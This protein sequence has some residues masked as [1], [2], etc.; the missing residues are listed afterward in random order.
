MATV[1]ERLA[2]LEQAKEEAEA[3]LTAVERR[4]R[5]WK[6]AALLA[7]LC[8]LLLGYPQLGQ[9]QGTLDQRVAVLEGKLARVS[10][11]NNRADIIITGAN[12]NLINGAGSTQTA[13]GLGNLIIGYNEAR[14]GGA[15]FRGGSHNLVIGQQANYTSFGGIIGGF[16]NQISGPFA[17]VLTGYQNG[18]LSFYACVTTG[19]GNNA[20]NTWAAVLGGFN[21]TASGLYSCVS[22]GGANTA[23][24]SLAAVSGGEFNIAS[25]GSAAISGGSTNTAS[26]FAASVSGGFQNVASGFAAAVSGGEE[27]TAAADYSTVG[28]GYSES[29][30]AGFSDHAWRAAGTLFQDAIGP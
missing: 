14:G 23:S 5:W 12:L 25:G 16:Q 1:E 8:G 20:A 2:A 19:Q 29:I 11:A 22:G 17:H 27:N 10:V 3:R 6:G 13:N 15:D 18:A 28:G 24:S 4:L 30:A 26:G 9:A 21:N 7:V